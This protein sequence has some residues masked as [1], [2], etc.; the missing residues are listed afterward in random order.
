MKYST[1]K[2]KE[3]WESFFYH[4]VVS[5]LPVRDCILESWIRCAKMGIPF[6]N[7]SDNSIS[8]LSQKDLNNLLEKKRHLIDVATPLMT[9]LFEHI[10]DSEYIIALTDENGVVLKSLCNDN[11]LL[12]FPER[13]ATPGKIFAERVA[14]TN[15]IGTAL[16]LNKPVCIYTT[17]HYHIHSHSF[18]CAG[19]PIHDPQGNTI[20]CLLLSCLE[21]NAN[22]FSLG[23]ISSAKDAIEKQLAIEYHLQ[24]ETI[25][26]KE[27]Y[28]ALNN[29]SNGI[30]VTD[31]E[32]K[33]I[34]INEYCKDIFGIK[35]EQTLGLHIND[36]LSIGNDLKLFLNSDKN[37][38]KEKLIVKPSSKTIECYFSVATYQNDVN[39]LQG[40]IVYVFPP[41]ST[42]QL[43]KQRTSFKASCTFDHIIGSSKLIEDAK[44]YATRAAYSDSSVLL[45]GESGTGKELFAQAIHNQ[46]N[47]RNG[48]F[49]PVNCGAL[50]KSLIE[51]ELFGYEGGSFT[52]SKKEGQL[53]KFELADGGTIFLDEIGDIPTDMQV[54]LLRVLQEKEFIRVGGKAP[55]K[56]DVRVIAATNKDIYK[57]IEQQ[58]FRIDLLYRLNV[59]EINIPALRDRK[60]DVQ[61]L[62]Q[63]FLNKYNSK[64]NKGIYNIGETFLE[65]LQRHSWPGNVREL[66]NVIERAVNLSTNGQLNV[67]HLNLSSGLHLS[68]QT[69]KEVFDIQNEQSLKNMPV[70][71]TKSHIIHLL[72]M[73]EGN[74]SD[75]A[76]ELG[77][78]RKTLYA[79]IKKYSI[80]LKSYRY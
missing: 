29:T 35:N 21:K 62:A 53:G 2:I 46:S 70:F 8:Y 33:I 77:V 26:N 78:T 59:F 34:Y 3:A 24:K 17:E 75:V 58:E 32:Y 69:S 13:A 6:D 45:L 44:D 28:H 61:I 1:E 41:S 20:G 5:D 11:V 23:I 39:N 52:G 27:L 42:T 51:S 74:I 55:V 72:E 56:V 67:L 64:L 49:I 73:Y 14:G 37:Y 47:R 80:D 50:P 48:P 60:G 57:A 79:K 7:S 12:K 65:Q 40:Y 9:K 63:Y 19:S 66:E 31:A 38:C 15:G 22:D 76:R 30:M 71:G 4:N 25:I 16:V 68:S 18:V 10:K 54:I 43:I 36:V